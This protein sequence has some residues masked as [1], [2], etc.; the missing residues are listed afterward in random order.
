[1]FHC[2]RKQMLQLS[3][4]DMDIKLD[5]ELSL[6]HAKQKYSERTYTGK[7]GEAQMRTSLNIHQ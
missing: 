4:R 2:P 6:V 5:I 7:G 3:A 1:M